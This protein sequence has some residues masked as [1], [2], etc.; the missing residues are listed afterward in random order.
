VSSWYDY[1]P[2]LGSAVEALKGNGKKALEDII[3]GVT[4]VVDAASTIY[5]KYKGAID[6]QKQGDQTAAASSFALG[7]NL[8]QQA[9]G[10]G[11]GLAQAENY[12]LPAKAAITAAYG[13]P[14][15]MTGGPS[16]YPLAPPRAK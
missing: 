14:G 5:D 13:Q 3:P 2:V 15:A 4:P 12:Y 11:G 1:V 8:Q 10:P 9:I 16:Q 6:Q 7:S